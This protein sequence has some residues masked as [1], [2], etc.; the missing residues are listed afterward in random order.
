MFYG[1]MLIT[2]DARWKKKKK[3]KKKK[4]EKKKERRK[5]KA[6]KRE[7]KRVSNLVFYAQSTGG[8]GVSDC[9]YIISA[10]GKRGDSSF[11]ITVS[12]R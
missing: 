12:H 7:K 8:A 6:I 9:G 2:S 4:K 1:Q 3:R 10:I 5:A 11:K